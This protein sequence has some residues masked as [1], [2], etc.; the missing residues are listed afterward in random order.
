MKKLIV[1]I[2]LLVAF[3]AQAK[4]EKVTVTGVLQYGTL[5]SSITDEKGGDVTFLSND[6]KSKKIFDKCHGGDTCKVTAMV[7]KKED[8]GVLKKVVSVELV[9][10]AD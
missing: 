3:S 1:L 7:E 9:K 4:D 2:G 6:K 5:D 8:T 10:R